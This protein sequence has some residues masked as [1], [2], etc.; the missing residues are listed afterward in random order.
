MPFSGTP[1]THVDGAAVVQQPTAAQPVD[2]L[3]QAGV[4]LRLGH[5]QKREAGGAHLFNERLLGVQTIGDDHRSQPGMVVTDA[6]Q[7][8][9]AGFYFTVLLAAF[10]ILGARV[11]GV[12]NEPG[13]QRQHLPLVGVDDGGLQDVVVVAYG[14]VV[15]ENGQEV[16]VYSRP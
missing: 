3:V 7:G 12:V 5:Q 1:V 14:E 13:S 6:L 9:V 15:L 16:K 2:I 8:T 4:I 11:I 10:G